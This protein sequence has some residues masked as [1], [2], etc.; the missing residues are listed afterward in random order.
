MRLF[1]CSACSLNPHCKRHNV[2][3]TFYSLPIPYQSYFIHYC[4]CFHSL[5]HWLPSTDLASRFYRWECWGPSPQGNNLL[6]IDRGGRNGRFL[7]QF[8]A[9]RDPCA[10]LHRLKQPQTMSLNFLPGSASTRTHPC[11]S[12]KRRKTQGRLYEGSSKLEK[13]H[14]GMA[15][16][17][18]DCWLPKPR[19]I[20]SQSLLSRLLSAE[21]GEKKTDICF[22][23][24]PWL[25][26]SE[27][28]S[29][30]W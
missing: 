16:A 20:H 21:T 11:P 7:S 18:T 29:L 22:P 24:F 30:Y 4:F 23:V 28:W 17:A 10:T 12:L 15:D 26:M 19:V 27:H 2:L 9:E 25:V 5:A 13:I 3:S 1:I 8:K 14:S 6:I